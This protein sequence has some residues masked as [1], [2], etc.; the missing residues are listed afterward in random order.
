MGKVSSYTV[1]QLKKLPPID[2]N[3]IPDN[4][5]DPDI[6]MDAN[7]DISDETMN[8]LIA[9]KHNLKNKNKLFK[10]ISIRLNPDTLQKL[11]ASGRGWQSRLRDA[12]DKLVKDKVL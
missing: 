4:M 1:E 7:N 5:I 8:R 2:V 3:S 12:I 9:E 6:E 10:A 11:R